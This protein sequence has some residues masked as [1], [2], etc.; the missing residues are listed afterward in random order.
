[1]AL[2]EVP[3]GLWIP[4]PLPS[5]TSYPSLTNVV[6]IDA[7]GEKFALIFRAPKTGTLDSFAFRLG[8]VTQAPT[9]GLKCSFQDVSLTTGHPDETVDQSATVTSG[10]TANAWVDPGAFSAGRSV[11]RGDLVAAVI[12]FAT[13]VAGDSLEFSGWYE[14]ATVYPLHTLY[15]ALKTGGTWV[16]A[17]TLPPFALKY[18][19]GSYAVVPGLYPTKNVNTVTFDSTTSP[20]ER[21]M[22]FTL[23][24]ACRLQG[25]LYRIE[26]VAG[27][28][29]DVVLYDAVSTVLETVT[30]D[31][32]TTIPG[33]AGPA[34]AM[35]AT[36]LAENTLYRVTLKPSAT[37]LSAFEFDVNAA[38]IM[39]AFGGG[40]AFHHTSRTDAGAWTDTT[41]KRPWMNL[42]LSQVDDGVGAAVSGYAVM[43]G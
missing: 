14:T 39:D 36:T 41:T 11:T 38:A 15:S 16:K 2:V 1:M 29:F 20:D 6:L 34:L 37:A 30:V 43:M 12:E 7:S 22:R 8:A 10:L 26:P 4:E 28:T 24:M 31:T 33:G 32:D 3:G 13:F 23:P 35:F 42:W 40:Q 25:V 19:D 5:S 18:T 27:T 17:Q 21:G 9:N